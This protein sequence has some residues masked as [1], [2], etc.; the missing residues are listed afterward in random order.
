[1]VRGATVDAFRNSVPIG[2]VCSIAV[3]IGVS[4]SMCSF[5]P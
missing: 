3:K 2:V 5:C 1:M 4:V